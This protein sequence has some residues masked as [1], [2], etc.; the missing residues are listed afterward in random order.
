MKQSDPNNNLDFVL[1]LEQ[2]FYDQGF[3][4]GQQESTKLQYLEGKVFGY[5][6]GFQRFLIVGYIAGLVEYWQTNIE[7][8]NI[9]SLDDHLENAQNLLNQI[10]LTNNEKDVTNYEKVLV[11]LRNKLRIISNLVKEQEKFKNVNQL[12]KEIGGDLTL[13]ENPNDMW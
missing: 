5:Q 2:D 12:I 10:S 4:Q 9:G 3:K 6:T 11:K 13:N 8:Y 7:K 1:N